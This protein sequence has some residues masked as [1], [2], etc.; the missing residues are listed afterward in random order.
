MSKYEGTTTGGTVSRSARPVKRSG[1]SSTKPTSAMPTKSQRRAGVKS[2]QKGILPL[3][4][5][6]VSR[7]G[8]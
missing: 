3:R 2:G 4:S 7:R 8:A 1:A 6:P 5:G